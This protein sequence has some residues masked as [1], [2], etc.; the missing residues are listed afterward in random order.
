MGKQFLFIYLAMLNIACA[1]NNDFSTL[2]KQGDYGYACFRIPTVITT[3]D[4]S[5]L[6]F[7]EARKMGCSDT[8]NIDIVLRKSIDNGETWSDVKIVWDDG[9]NVSGNPSPVIDRETGDIHL[10][11]T[12]NNG[13]DKEA[14]IIA[15][16]SI[17]TRRVFHQVSS[18]DGE[19]WS[20][21]KDITQ[22][23]K[24]SNWTWYATGPVHGIQLSKGP[25]KGRMIIASDHIEAHTDKYYSH[26]IYSDDHGDTW[27]LG[28]S[29]PNDQVNES[30][31]AELNN[32]DLILNM[33]NYDRQ[34]AQVR[35][36]A[37]SKDAGMTWQD[38]RYDRALPEP[39]CQG[40]LLTT[41]ND[42]L[43]FTNPADSNNR[44]NMTLSISRDQGKTWP[45]KITL[46]D[47]HAAYSD[48]TELKD[49]RIIVLFE[50]GYETPYDGIHYKIL[51]VK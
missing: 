9:D 40:A 27:Q 29:S 22:T 25:N 39:Q 44:V 35:Q 17:D 10:L 26:I 15:L 47:K 50:A 31:V 23:T 42:L 20:A 16:K 43:L 2:Y 32:G 8:G 36:I 37:I 45:D 19:N 7:A 38:Q 41:K 49:D 3:N 51:D 13:Q 30:T 14:D 46:F 48:L 28:G 21:A 4:G 5:I 1:D 12:W 6:A 24:L 33:R 34:D 11:S 18:D